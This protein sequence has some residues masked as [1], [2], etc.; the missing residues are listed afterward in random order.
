MKWWP[1]CLAIL[2]SLQPCSPTRAQQNNRTSPPWTKK[3]TV[4]FAFH[5]AV[6]QP[7]AALANRYG[8]FLSN[9]IAVGYH[10]ANS[11]W[12]WSLVY[13][14]FFGKTVKEDPLAWLRDEYGHIYG[15]DESGA[16]PTNVLLRLRGS[17]IGAAMGYTH[18]LL[19]QQSLHHFIQ[20]TFGI[21][22][23]QHRIYFVDDSRSVA[24]LFG[25]YGRG[26]DRL[27]GGPSLRIALHYRLLDVKNRRNFSIALFTYLARTRN[28]RGFNYDQMAYDRTWRIDS[29]VGISMHYH[30][31][32]YFGNPS[33]ELIFY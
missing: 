4:E 9:G 3:H 13:D 14:Y 28:L 22:A 31:R 23:M 10:P 33:K 30:L 19:R 18:R 16:T 25:E 24:Q 11:P 29:T 27:S 5:Y 7:Y 15:W 21:G 20:W 12:S 1:A 17:W 6:Q 26:L 8:T 2:L 32:Y